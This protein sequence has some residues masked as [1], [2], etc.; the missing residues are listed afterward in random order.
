MNLQQIKLNL[1]EEFG[2]VDVFF[3]NTYKRDLTK[4]SFNYVA[5]KKKGS[6]QAGLYAHMGTNDYFDTYGPKVMAI[7]VRRT[8]KPAIRPVDDT[9]N[10]DKDE[11]FIDQADILHMEHAD[12]YDY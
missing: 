5:D 3:H 2:E 8:V 12:D 9:H 1:K 10:A 4:G 6:I 7:L 11:A